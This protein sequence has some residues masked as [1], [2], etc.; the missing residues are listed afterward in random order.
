MR[1][2]AACSLLLAAALTPALAA[3]PPGA[4]ELALEAFDEAQ[5]LATLDATVYAPS[6]YTSP[7]DL[8]PVLEVERPYQGFN[9]WYYFALVDGK[10]WFK[11]R[12]KR[13]AGLDELVVDL[14]WRPFG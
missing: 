5:R 11:P 12:V 9:D 1:R 6:P 14:P 13:R 10:V 2:L 3:R 8:P 7:E 4:V